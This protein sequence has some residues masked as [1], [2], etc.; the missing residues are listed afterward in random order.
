M[1]TQEKTMKYQGYRK[2]SETSKNK[3]KRTKRKWRDLLQKIKNFGKMRKRIYSNSL[4]GKE[5]EEATTHLIKMMTTIS[6]RKIIDQWKKSF[7]WKGLNVN[8]TK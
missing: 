7:S 5:I 2:K 8:D 1:I 6:W 3:Q 4:E